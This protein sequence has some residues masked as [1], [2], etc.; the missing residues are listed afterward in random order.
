[1]QKAVL[2]I[3]DAKVRRQLTPL[4]GRSYH[5]STG[6]S[7]GQ[8]KEDFDLCVL[9]H[10]ALDELLAKTIVPDTA[11]KESERMPGFSHSGPD[12][13][14]EFASNGILT[15]ANE[16]VHKLAAQSGTTA[17][18][19]LPTQ[20]GSIVREC[21]AGGK[22]KHH[23]ETRLGSHPMAWSF[24]PIPSRHVVWC[25]ARDITEQLNVETQLRQSQKLQ[26]VGQLASGV[27]HDF[28]NMLTAILGHTSLLLAEKNQPPRT[29]DSLKQIAE[30]AERA[31]CLTRQ[32]LAFSRQ[33]SM[34][35]QPLDVNEVIG[36]LTKMLRRIIGED[37][38]LNFGYSPYLPPVL[39]DACMLEQIVL[40]L[41]VNARDAM[42]KGGQLTIS[43]ACDTV[44]DER[45]HKHPN[46]RPGRFVRFSVTDT[47][48][49]IAADVA[50]HIFE[51][52]FT[53][54]DVGKGTGIGLATVHGIVQQ[55][56]GWVEVESFEGIGSNFIIYLP[57]RP[58]LKA[59]SHPS[60]KTMLVEGRGETVLLVEDE[61]VV[62]QVART[63]L[64]RC[65]YQ[66]LEAS[67]G[68]TAREVW[69][70]QAGHIDLLLS[71]MVMPDGVSGQT[72][73]KELRAEK[74]DL[75]VLLVSGYG[76]GKPDEA[77]AK[78]MDVRYLQKPFALSTFTQAVR[79]CLEGRTPAT[80]Q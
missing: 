19:I 76:L 70:Q 9:D 55:H 11:V 2:L 56:E 62:R 34:R 39:G 21:L 29:L 67:S 61:S 8:L 47:G 57:A 36:N 77:W 38:K 20:C 54:K 41:A 42:P 25:Y 63:A 14:F 26:A 31:A 7:A 23:I 35:P 58:D 37:I 28:N 5:V 43:T 13:V 73:A 44:S 45:A 16:A 40:N 65:G 50:P 24:F 80:P 74:P 71:D 78:R 15:Y 6:E 27:A 52:F 59:A 3:R 69:R 64:E 53:T 68:V 17:S 4:L 1:M 66:V 72:L 18:A 12:Y 51:P 49:G 32:L 60:S 48:C 75:K 33:Q 79:D 46:A 10:G 30:A 22:D